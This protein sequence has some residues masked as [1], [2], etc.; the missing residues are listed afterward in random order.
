MNKRIAGILL[1]AP[2]LLNSCATTGSTD[3]VQ[4]FKYTIRRL[5]ERLVTNPQD[6]GALRDLGVI[7]FESKQYGQAREYL[8][9]SSLANG[10]DGKT[11]FYLG[12][13]QE[14]D[15]DL[16][17]AL[18]SYLNYMDLPSSSPFRKLMEGRYQ[19]VTRA[20]IAQQFRELASNEQV[21]AKQET[22]SNAVAVFPLVYEGSD[23]RFSSLGLGLSEM[24]TV[25]LGQVKKLK[26]VE[27]L[28]VDEL[29]DELKFGA[30]SAVDPSTAPRVGKLL[31]A[32]RLVGGR[33]TVGADNALRLDVASLDVVRDKEPTTTTQSDDLDNLFKVQK[34]IVFD[35]VKK[36]GITLTREEREAIQRVPT[37]NLQA[38]IA[39]SIGLEKEG[40]G[41]FEAASVYFKQA[42][43]LDPSFEKAKGKAEATDAMSASGTSKESA[44]FAAHK[45]SPPP[46]PSDQDRRGGARAL[47]TQRFLKLEMA[48]QVGFVP[49]QNS[50]KAAQELST[51]GVLLNSLPLPPPPPGR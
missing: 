31:A 10:N 48:I 5:Q 20:L 36:M 16:N 4:D 33:F 27:R 6:A 49:G 42:S 30:S 26:L 28:R 8:K 12:M 2:L 41:D 47:L 23:P 24:M 15:Q 17:G 46:S 13:T 11:M 38:F 21:L 39:Y 18:A 40:Q 44:L 37:K 7:Y 25:D 50:R 9:K 51:L 22:P 19:A 29:M 32:G 14:Y 34:E 45:I 35:V 3:T 43:A 1:F